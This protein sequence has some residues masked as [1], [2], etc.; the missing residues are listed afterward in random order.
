MYFYI[1]TKNDIILLKQIQN[2]S[3][4]DIC[5]FINILNVG[6]KNNNLVAQL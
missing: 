6:A 5:I 2:G 3:F 4:N 1:T